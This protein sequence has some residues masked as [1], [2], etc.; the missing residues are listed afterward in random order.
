[1]VRN[2]AREQRLV[3]LR[4]L[5]PAEAGLS[6]VRKDASKA[7]VEALMAAVRGSSQLTPEVKAAA[8]TAYAASTPFAQAWRAE[9]C[10]NKRGDAAPRARQIM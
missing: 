5:L 10:T 8:E 7:Q 9:G 2:E 3:E 6:R 1:M 4:D